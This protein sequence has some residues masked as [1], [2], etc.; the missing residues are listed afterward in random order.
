VWSLAPVF[1][2]PQSITDER[3]RTSAPLS[4]LSV[5]R[6]AQQQQQPQQQQLV[7]IYRSR[8]CDTTA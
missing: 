6:Y 8:R 4:T 3:E 2:S 5:R 1:Q 7:V